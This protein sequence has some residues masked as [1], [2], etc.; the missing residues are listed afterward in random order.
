MQELH[1]RGAAG[2]KPPLSENPGY[3]TSAEKRWPNS[4]KPETR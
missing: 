2:E 1:A 3:L 4:G